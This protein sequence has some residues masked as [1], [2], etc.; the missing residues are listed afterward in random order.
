VSRPR[1][2]AETPPDLRRGTSRGLR[3]PSA[4]T[5]SPSAGPYSRP[6]PGRAKHGRRPRTAAGAW[7]PGSRPCPVSPSC[8][9]TRG[10]QEPAPPPG[11][12]RGDGRGRRG[13]PH[14]HGT[15][16]DHYVARHRAVQPPRVRRVRGRARL[17]GGRPA[18]GDRRRP[19]V[20]GGDAD[21]GGSRA[22]P[23]GVRRDRRLLGRR[24]EVAARLE[25]THRH[26]CAASGADPTGTAEWPARTCSAS[27]RAC[28]R[29]ISAAT[30]DCWENLGVQGS[31]SRSP[32]RTGVVG[33][34]GRQDRSRTTS[35]GAETWTPWS[36]RSPST[37]RRTGRPIWPSP[38]HSI[39]PD[40]P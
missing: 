21:P 9:T 27:G 7:T 25:E 18:V 6:G 15:G 5:A 38:A 37:R 20:R 26:A 3:P 31:T 30:G 24:R 8:K 2:T 13:H 40:G 4:G 14:R 33:P 32:R 35:P 39:R 16:A 28:Q 22:A 23:S 36:P 10:G 17:C 12:P 11:G 1:C 19:C 29:S 34:A